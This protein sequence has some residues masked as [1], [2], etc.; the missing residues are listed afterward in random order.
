MKALIWLS[1]NC[2]LDFHDYWET[3]QDVYPSESTGGRR[4]QGDGKAEADRR[5]LSGNL[6]YDSAKDAR[7][8][9]ELER[10]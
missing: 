1:R 2:L 3:M 8:S 5:V 10:T 9:M 7:I 6:L 4:A